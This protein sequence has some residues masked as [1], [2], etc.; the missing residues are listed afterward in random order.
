MPESLDGRPQRLVL[1]P[2]VGPLAMG[3]RNLDRSVPELGGALDLGDRRLDVLHRGHRHRREPVAVGAEVLHRPVVPRL[4]DRELIVRRRRH[5]Q[6][7]RPVGIDDLGGDAVALQVG[8]TPVDVPSFGRVLAEFAIA[9]VLGGA[10]IGDVEPP[11]APPVD[12]EVARP[13]ALDDARRAVAERLRKALE[14]LGG[15]LHVRIGRDDLVH[16]YP[17]PGTAQVRIIALPPIRVE[18]AAVHPCSLEVPGIP[19]RRITS[20]GFAG[21]T[22]RTARAG[23]PESPRVYRRIHDS[24][25]ESY[26]FAATRPGDRRV[27][28][29]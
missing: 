9:V 16:R 1:R 2:V 4:R 3:D 17:P 18:D 20:T 14:D 24:R 25:G 8:E 22:V 26:G 27:A 13:V 7:E 23:T 12:D 29:C 28:R 6:V 21:M 5:E 11:G 15:L 10:R 19:T